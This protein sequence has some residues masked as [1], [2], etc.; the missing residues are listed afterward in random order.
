ME[1]VRIY[2][3]LRVLS[4]MEAFVRN[5]YLIAL[6]ILIGMGNLVLALIFNAPTDHTGMAH[7]AYQL[8]R[9]ALKARIISM[10]FAFPSLN[11]ACLATSGLDLA[12]S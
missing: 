1:C 3:V 5:I 8:L 4:G 7:T 11:L 2:L 6:S 10:E 12:V 9:I